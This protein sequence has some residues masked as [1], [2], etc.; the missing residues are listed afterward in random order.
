MNKLINFLKVLIL[1]LLLIFLGYFLFTCRQVSSFEGAP[2]SETEIEIPQEI[3]QIE[4]APAEQE[5]IDVQDTEIS[6][7]EAE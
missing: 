4:E 7:N 2:E 5:Q 3:P 6:E 1:I